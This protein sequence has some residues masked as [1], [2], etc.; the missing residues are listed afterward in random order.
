MVG[1]PLPLIP[2]LLSAADFA[3]QRDGLVA[4][5]RS[6]IDSLYTGFQ[7]ELDAE[8][9]E[10]QLAERIDTLDP[11]QHLVYTAISEWAERRLAWRQTESSQ[12]LPADAPLL[13]L[14]LL[15]NW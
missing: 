2:N 8:G 12:A 14:L 9:A 7:K 6:G 11:T 13:R 1:W 5:L 4:K 10:T 3:C 15:G